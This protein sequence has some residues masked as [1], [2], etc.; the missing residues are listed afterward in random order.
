MTTTAPYGTW[1]SPISAV[2]TV[3]GAVRFSD[4]QYDDGALYWL[5]G[6][7]TEGGRSVLVRR[8]PD[9]TA[10]E[11]LASDVN[12]RTMVHEYGG[13]AYRAHAGDV[14]YSE[15]DDQ[16]LYRL[17]TGLAL[18]AEQPRERS[19]RYADAA[20]LADGSIVCVRET[21]PT[22][23]EAMN[24]LVRIAA[25]GTE[26]VIATGADFY[27]YPAVSQD[28][29]KMAW[30][31]WDH[32][33]MP[34]DDTRLVIASLADL[35][36]A[37]VVAGGPGESV[38]QPTWKTDGSLV[39]ISDRTGW[40]NLY[41]LDGD[42]TQIT[43]RAADFASPAWLFGERSYCVLDDGRI[44]VTFW[45][46]GRHHL[47]IV[48]TD[49]ALGVIDDSYASYR[50]LAT[51]SV[52]RVWFVGSRAEQPT[53][54]V[55]Y[56]LASGDVRNIA[57][58]ASVVAEA[59]VSVPELI[60]FPTT[61]GESA[62]AVFYSPQNPLFTAPGSERPPLLVHIH[63]GPTSH[64][65][66]RYD[67]GILFWTTRGF[68]VV[69]VNYRGS[70]SFG[71]EYRRKLTGEWGVYDVDDAVAAATFLAERGDVDGERLAIS[72]GSAGGYTALAALAFRD[73]FAA[74]VSYFGVADIEVLAQDTH[75]FESRYVSGLVGDDPELWR[76][77]SPL[78]S[79]D[80]ISVPVALFQ[81]LDDTVVPPNQATMIAEALGRNHVPH[82]H[83]EYEGEGHGFRRSENIINTLETELI[84][85]GAV[86]GFEPAGD[87]PAID[88]STA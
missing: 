37:V 54:I 31:E 55:E 16:R 23:G 70:T 24:E 46:G 4:I 88:L 2:D 35:S 10:D 69:D 52:N 21:H 18:T 47:G 8:R 64:V 43:S 72:G 75:K 78:Y 12:V 79:A 29:D 60:T 59:F 48:D 1:E 62:H 19:V 5:E 53:A 22:S 11:P 42:V 57:S 44:V 71:R 32:P 13:G 34:W 28:G 26:S 51:D 36:D 80:D 25:D 45:E 83:I 74:G 3:A 61:F 56:A 73:I 38:L 63:G 9:G 82:L 14:V 77:R 76:S 67:A 84:F 58:N 68:G 17:E 87:L 50:Y 39:F 27:A 7:P 6:R 41:R 40:W 66:P 30:V 86:L 15:F 81:G 65:T 49:G 33:N 85:Y 20:G